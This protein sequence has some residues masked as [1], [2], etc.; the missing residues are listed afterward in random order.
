MRGETLKMQ[1]AELEQKIKASQEAA[2]S[3]PKLEH[4]VELIQEKLSMPDFETKRMVLEMLDVKV[5][6]DG[7][8]VVVIGVI[9]IPDYGTATAQTGLSGHNNI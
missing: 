7:R 4:F 2:I 5:Q 6:L 3:L 1:K 8:N 9:P